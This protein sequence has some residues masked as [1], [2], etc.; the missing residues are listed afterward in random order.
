MIERIEKLLEKTDIT[1]II[2]SVGGLVLAGISLYVIIY[3]FGMVQTMTIETNKV[4]R[5]NTS[6]LQANTEITRG[7]AEMLS[8]IVKDDK[9]LNAITD[10]INIAIGL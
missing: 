8:Q 10:K 9:K 1:K 6:A 7:F 2:T 5:E 3:I 4:L